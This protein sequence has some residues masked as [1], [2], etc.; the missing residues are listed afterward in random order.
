M[1]TTDERLKQILDALE[2]FEGRVAYIYN[3]S[4]A[5]PNR[6]VGVGCLL[7]DAA[8]ACLLPFGNVTAG[9]PATKDEIAADFARV[10]AMP[11]GQAARH[12]QAQPG[13]TAIGLSDD[14]ITALAITKLRDEFLPGLIGLCPGF[15][16]FPE[17][18]QSAL[19]DMAWNLGLGVP[20]TPTRRATGLHGFPSLL[21]AC[22]RG[23]WPT[24]AQQSHVATSRDNRNAWRA[25][26]FTAAGAAA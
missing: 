3:D 14:D 26:Q 2:Q 5:P 15:E 8:A 22:N 19:L 18:A 11:G 23:D 25:A 13:T 7:K 4:A 10:E 16:D 17:P 21:A 9:R 24:A 1:P 12:Y 6:T 20:A